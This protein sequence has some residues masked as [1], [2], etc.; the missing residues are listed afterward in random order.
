MVKGK[1]H[2]GRTLFIERN[3]LIPK[4]PFFMAKIIVNRDFFSLNQNPTTLS[5]LFQTRDKNKK[6]GLGLKLNCL[7]F[8]RLKVYNLKS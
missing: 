4:Q 1:Q 7:N 8:K 6:N 3:L 5:L 2:L